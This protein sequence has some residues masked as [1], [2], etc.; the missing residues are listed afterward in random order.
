MPSGGRCES[1]EGSA[2]GLGVVSDRS[3]GGG[4]GEAPDS[5]DGA[6]DGGASDSAD[7]GVGQASDGAGVLSVRD[8]EDLI[9][10]TALVRRPS[11]SMLNSGFRFDM[12]DEPFARRR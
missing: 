11:A 4:A 6:G 2:D 10:L 1:D 8:V 5:P 3:D 7:E 9:F 12:V